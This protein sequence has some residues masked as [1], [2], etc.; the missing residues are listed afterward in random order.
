[1]SSYTTLHQSPG[2]IK[3]KEELWSWA[4]SEHR[5][6]APSSLKEGCRKPVLGVWELCSHS[7]MDCLAT[8]LFLTSCFSDAVFVT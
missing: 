8:E 2:E 6:P 7:R 1:M 3:R 5:F 4:H